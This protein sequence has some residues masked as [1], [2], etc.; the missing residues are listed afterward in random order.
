[1]SISD[2][3]TQELVRR[4]SRG[5]HGAL[6]DLLGRH[7]KRLGRM[8]R[9]RMDPRVR[10]R[11][12]PSDVIQ[13]AFMTVS[14]Q[15]AQYLESQPI[16]FYPW[17]RRIVWQKLARAHEQHLDTAKRA[18][19][20]EQ[21]CQWGISD[22]SAMRI[23]KVIAGSLTS[24]SGAAIRKETRERVRAALDELSEFDREVLLQRYVERLSARE[25]A[26]VLDTTEAA[27][28]KRH[29]RALQKLHRLLQEDS[30]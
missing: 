25:I 17:L 20:R 7:R 29:A 27:I 10:S 26:D 19:G 21:R 6:A 18:I 15:L 22:H 28:H 14:Q 1:M 12:D 9:T 13:E 3:E 11:V 16:P 4:A 23:G 5:D 8:V 24:P 2:A 30:P